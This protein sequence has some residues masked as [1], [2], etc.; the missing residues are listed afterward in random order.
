MTIMAVTLGEIEEQWL[1]F[2]E[3]VIETKKRKNSLLVS[4]IF[5]LFNMFNLFIAPKR[6]WFNF[7]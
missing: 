3:T 1:L 7:K 6:S 5:N 4:N 2:I